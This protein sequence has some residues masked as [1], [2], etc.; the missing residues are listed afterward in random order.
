MPSAEIPT[1]EA[2]RAWL[3]ESPRVAPLMTDLMAGIQAAF[4]GARAVVSTYL[5]ND[6]VV[7]TLVAG[8][9]GGPLASALGAIDAGSGRRSCGPAL[10]GDSPCIVGDV[11]R[12]GRWDHD[13]NVANRHGVRAG[14]SWRLGPAADPLGT[15][16]LYWREPREPTPSEL[17]LADE[18]VVLAAQ[19][20]ERLGFERLHR[21]D[22]GRRHDLLFRDLEDGLCIVE[23]LFDDDDRPVDYR[24]LEVN[25][26]FE[27]QTGLANAVGRTAR[28][29][30]PGLDDSWFEMYGAI[31][32][33]GEPR[34]F[35]NEAPAMGRSFEVS[36]FRFG[37]PAARQV[38]ILFRDVTERI[39]AE[40]RLRE[41]EAAARETADR[42]AFTFEHMTD[43]FTFI[44]DAWRAV[45]VNPVAER[46]LQRPREELLGR[47]MWETFPELV[48]SEVER[49][50]RSVREE[51]TSASF[52]LYFAP[53]GHWFEAHV[54]AVQ[55][56]IATFFRQI[57]ERKRAEA[58]L[59]ASEERLRLVARAAADLIWD[60]D[61]TRRV[62]YR[63]LPGQ[64]VTETTVPDVA[65]WALQVVEAERDQVAESLQDAL[66]GDASAWEATYHM[67]RSDGSVREVENSC[68]IVRD[69]AGTAVRVVGSLADVTERSE[70]EERQAR[71]RRL[72]SV[73][74]LT[75]GV[76]HDFNNLLT[77]VL[78]TSDVLADRLADQPALAHMAGMI[79]KAAERGA[80]LT[81]MLLAFARRQPLNP[82]STDVGAQL[83]DLMPLLLRTIGE[84]VELELVVAPSSPAALIDPHGL[85]HAVLNLCLNARDAMP[86]GGK[87]IIEVEGAELTE[88]YAAQHEDVTAGAYLRVAVTDTGHG[89]PP[90]VLARAFEPFFTTKPPGTGTGLGLSSVFGFVKQSGGHIQVYSEEGSGTA[91]RMYLPVADDAARAV[92]RTIEGMDQRGTETI[93]V[94]EDDELVRVHVVGQLEALGYVVVAAPDGPSAI[95]VIEARDD[96]DLLFTDVVMSGGMTGRDLANAAHERRPDLRVLYTSGYTENAIV[97]HG[98]LDAGVRLLSKPY[99]RQ[100]L[101]AA[102]RAALDEG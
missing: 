100:A 9:G 20:L 81:R 48:G 65:S 11:D 32:R 16:A 67:R 54:H 94:V 68:A 80:D 85:E 64:A 28:E 23:V 43:G 8:P 83:R 53:L 29:L 91:I 13:R 95:A 31:A 101:A 98:R 72:E 77:V 27:E 38:A 62:L 52:E 2:V 42:L 97:H 89:M 7:Q 59:R 46:L 35:T 86:T 44:D 5:A 41:V 66:D 58:D 57:D 63:G 10:R 96:I 37:D 69:S 26:A 14:W 25:D 40:A 71:A 84:D 78:G 61:L 60:W 73:G 56:G 49:T 76:A 15:L 51:G 18:W 30:V 45:L 47:T 12:D 50:Y 93:L 19:M 99:D 24:F 74:Q 21:E 3:A 4:P 90:H 88:A 102:V 55:G 36:A 79:R 92:R 6:D 82:L 33:T 39:R 75:G 1:L 87:L 70:L 17:E 22:G 34:R